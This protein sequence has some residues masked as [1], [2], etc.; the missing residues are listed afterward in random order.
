MR[1]R[2][3]S[4]ELRRFI[5][6]DIIAGA[7][8]EAITLNRY[9]YANG[10]PVS[11][12]DPFGLSV[13]DRWETAQTAKDILQ[14]IDEILS[15][16][17]TAHEGF[18]IERRI[19]DGVEKII[20]FGPKDFLHSKDIN[21]LQR[22]INAENLSK[23]P[24]IQKYLNPAT[25]VTD[26]MSSYLDVFRGT[27]KKASDYLGVAGDLLFIGADIIIE[28]IEYEEWEDKAIVGGYTLVKGAVSAVASTAVA[29]ASSAAITTL[30]AKAGG[31][32]GTMITPGV[33]TAIGAIIGLAAGWLVGEL[34][35]LG[36]ETFIESIVENN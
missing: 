33:G 27:A 9:A 20:I 18:R 5:N 32:I 4:P 13:E 24:N 28:T 19:I 11:N 23:Y 31:A 8:S 29:A 1:A 26:A 3:Y 7:I 2:Y 35:D 30:A 6:A 10:N 16:V 14:T 17:E 36:K 22:I 25:S 12:I 21:I 15:G 34:F